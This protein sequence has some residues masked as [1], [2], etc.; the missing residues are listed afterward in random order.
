M[1]GA[2]GYFGPATTKAVI[3]FQKAHR[4]T[5]DGLVGP[6]TWKALTAG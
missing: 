1:P 3:A 6:A 2:N 4:L 5:P